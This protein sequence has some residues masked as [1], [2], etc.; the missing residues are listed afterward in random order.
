MIYLLG[1]VFLFFL[2]L[3]ALRAF[4]EANPTSLA[5]VIRRGGGGAAL[6]AGYYWGASTWR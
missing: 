5:L 2:V 4:A 6:P 1:G 3:R